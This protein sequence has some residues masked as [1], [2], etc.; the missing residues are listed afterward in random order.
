MR[1]ARQGHKTWVQGMQDMGRMDARHWYDVC[2]RVQE[3]QE[4][5]TRGARQW[6]KTWAQGAQ[7][8]GMRGCIQCKKR[9]TRHGYKVWAQ[10]VQVKDARI[11]RS[12]RGARG[13]ERC[14]GYKRCEGR[15]R[16]EGCKPLSETFTT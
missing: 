9:V 15:K 11:A 6:C 3:V 2:E 14:G 13:C 5:G 7:D 16:C 4:R 8:M 1:G 12:E 10:G